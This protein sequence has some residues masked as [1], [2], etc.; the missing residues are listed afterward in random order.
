MGYPRVPLNSWGPVRKYQI[1]HKANLSFSNTCLTTLLPLW[2]QDSVSRLPSWN[3]LVYCNV[4][5]GRSGRETVDR[6]PTNM[7]SPPCAQDFGLYLHLWSSTIWV[8][9]LPFWLQSAL[10]NTY[11]T[12][13]VV[14]IGAASDGI[15]F[16]GGDVEN[17]PRQ[18]SPCTYAHFHRLHGEVAWRLQGFGPRGVPESGEG[19]KSANAHERVARKSAEV[20]SEVTQLWHSEVLQQLVGFHRPGQGLSKRDSVGREKRHILPRQGMFSGRP[21]VSHLTHGWPAKQGRKA[22]VQRS[23]SLCLSSSLYSKNILGVRLRST[24]LLSWVKRSLTTLEI[25]H[26]EFLPYCWCKWTKLPRSSLICPFPSTWT[27]TLIVANSGNREEAQTQT[28]S[29]P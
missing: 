6:H 10:V 20:L 24:S 27:N 4:I 22:T 23:P 7:T 29:G 21:K 13:A 1:C 14:A 9:C 3:P 8:C 19:C 12:T 2:G 15:W 11:L 26:K 17:T 5:S 28:I 25:I 16:V 18:A